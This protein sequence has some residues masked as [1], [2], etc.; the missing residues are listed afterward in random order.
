MSILNVTDSSV[1]VERIVDAAQKIE[2]E[3]ERVETTVKE[4]AQTVKAEVFDAQAAFKV[5]VASQEAQIRQ[6]Q[7]QIQALEA[8]AASVAQ[9]AVEIAKEVVD[10]PKPAE[11]VVTAAVVAPKV[12]VTDAQLQ[13]KFGPGF[14][15]FKSL[16]KGDVVVMFAQNGKTIAVKHFD[17]DGSVVYSNDKL[18][19]HS[20]KPAKLLED[21]RIAYYCESSKKYKADHFDGANYVKAEISK[22]EFEKASA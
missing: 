11:V 21:G 13:A 15:N 20:S 5:F 19:S 4:A 6:L 3:K 8:K 9:P 22:K 16:K 10:A 7:Q 2:Q 18:T 14:G 1:V 17:K 12:E